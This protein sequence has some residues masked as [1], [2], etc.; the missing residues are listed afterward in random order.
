MFTKYRQNTFSPSNCER[1]LDEYNFCPEGSFSNFSVNR[2]DY[3]LYKIRFE[4]RRS[5]IF[6]EKV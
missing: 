6:L 2:T 3:K 4:N 1:A 5:V